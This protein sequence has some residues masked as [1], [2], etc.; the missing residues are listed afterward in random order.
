MHVVTVVA[1]QSVSRV[2]NKLLTQHAD[3]DE[4]TSMKTINIKLN[5]NI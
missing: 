2:A 4:S 5:V 1:E 3:G